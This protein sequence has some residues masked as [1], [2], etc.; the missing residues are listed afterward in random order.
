MRVGMWCG[1]ALRVPGVREPHRG[2]TLPRAGAARTEA[3]TAA[4]RG[5]ERLRVGARGPRAG[6]RGSHTGGQGAEPSWGW[7]A[8]REGVKGPRVRGAKSRATGGRDG[9]AGRS[10]GRTG[11]GEGPR[12]R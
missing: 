10:R 6:D 4:R 3:G 8:T 5:L 1:N 7:G 11:G 12:A 9:C 2:T